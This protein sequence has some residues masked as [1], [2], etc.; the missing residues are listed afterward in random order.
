MSPSSKTKVS[1]QNREETL[2]VHHSRLGKIVS[3]C[4]YKIHALGH[5]VTAI[6]RFGT[7]DSYST[8]VVCELEFLSF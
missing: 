1:I 2:D 6:A 8:Q 7:T 5:Y 3:M 4:T